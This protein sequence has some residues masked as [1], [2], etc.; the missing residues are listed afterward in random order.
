VY[1]N[2]TILSLP[3][4][5]FCNDERRGINH[6]A[7]VTG[8]DWNFSGLVDTNLGLPFWKNAPLH[9]TASSPRAWTVTCCKDPL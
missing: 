1:L 8:R 4:Q 6:A 3:N 7:H 5:L 9:K 2:F